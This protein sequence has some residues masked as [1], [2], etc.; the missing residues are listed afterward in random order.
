V[1]VVDHAS[2]WPAAVLW[3]QEL[4]DAGQRVMRR[5][6]NAYP[7][8]LWEWEPFQR[9]M[10][11]DDQPYVVT[12]PDVIPSE[13][14][15]ADWPWYLAG[16]LERQRGKV[17]KAALG[18]RLDRLPKDERA[19]EVREY[20]HVFWRDAHE[21]QGFYRANT[22]TTLAVYQPFTEVPFF[23]LGPAVRS[24]FPYVAHHL[25]WYERG[26]PSPELAY[27]RAHGDPGH[28]VQRAWRD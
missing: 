14:C 25:A 26:E 3:L 2:S 12:D 4:E 9:L 10:C 24:G 28:H 13:E 11:A 5:G 1:I 15:P 19:R 6:S 17:I 7:W 22:D 18:L 8:Q 21:E 20:E 16:L 27:Y 23:T